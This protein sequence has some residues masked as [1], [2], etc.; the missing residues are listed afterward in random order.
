[1]RTLVIAVLGAFVSMTAF[2]FENATLRIKNI[3]GRVFERSVKFEKH[4]GGFYRIEIPVAEI[5]RDIDCIDVIA[6]AAVARQREP[7]FFVLGDSSY[8]EFTQDVGFYSPK[9]QHMPIFGM[10]TPHGAFVAIVK[11]LALEQKSTIEAKDGVYRAFPRFKIKDM[12]FDAYE[13]IVVDFYPLSGS[14]ATYSGMARVYRNYQLGRGEVKLLRDRIKDNPTLAYTAES[15]YVR[16]KHARKEADRNKD[17]MQTLETEP[18]LKIFH[19]FDDLADI[20]K[21]MKAEGI[22]KAEICSVGWNIGGHDGRFPQ[23]F[24][25]EPKLGGEE[26]FRRAIGTAKDLGFHINCHINQYSVFFISNR[27]NENDLAKK[28]DGNL[29]QDY[30]QP[31]GMAFRPCFQRLFNQWVKDDFRQIADLGVNGT[32]HIDVISYVHPYPC[33]ET[34]HPLNRQQTADYQNKVGEYA[35]RVFGGLA[36]EGG[37][38]H[39]AKTLDVALYLWSYPSWQNDPKGLATRHVPLWQLVYHGIIL[40][41]PY[42][43]TIDAPYPKVYETSDQRKAYDYLDNPETRW[44]KVVEFNGRPTFYYIDYKDLLPMKRVY[45]EYQSMSHLQYQL[46]VDHEEV[47]PGVFVSRF[48]NGEEVAVN[49]SETPFVYRGAS[50]QSRSYKLLTNRK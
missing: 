50:V 8:G 31:G 10:K 12:Y 20:T 48:E 22:D 9:F 2:G 30:F 38:D 21:R 5:T 36:S 34:R 37:L 17:K 35:H 3:D 23:Y 25:V 15:I 28:P 43:S 11:G 19:T 16:I 24:P 42:Y 14:D 40:S 47:S 46:M 39:L 33:C 45:A 13:P 32:F 4:N 7:G 27:W 44:L 41:N 26:K 49:Y 18:P 6:D 1:M 29:F